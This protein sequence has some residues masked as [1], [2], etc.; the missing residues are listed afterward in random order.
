MTYSSSIPSIQTHHKYLT[1]YNMYFKFSQ[2]KLLLRNNIIENK[3]HWSLS[4]TEMFLN[5][6][7]V[8]VRLMRV[9]K[10]DF[11]IRSGEQY[12]FGN[13]VIEDEEAGL[14]DG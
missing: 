12:L 8:W 3:T 9:T 7:L 13:V 14:F 11:K 2:V 6:R 1:S 5:F 4:E 10:Q